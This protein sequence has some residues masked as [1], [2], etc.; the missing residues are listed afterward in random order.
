[1]SEAG[2]RARHR[3]GLGH[4]AN[5]GDRVVAVLPL[6]ITQIDLAPGARR[7]GVD[8]LAA[9]DETDI[10]RGAARK[11]GEPV[12]LRDL[13]RQLLDR[14]DAVLE[15]RARMGGFPRDL[16]S[17]KDAALSPARDLA[18]DPARFR[19]EDGARAA[20]LGLDHGTRARGGDFL[21]AGDES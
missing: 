6:H 19:V 18:P 14:R 3:A 2:G 15:I 13:S 4:L 1:D 7:D 20:R 11:I 17:G 9:A 8:R 21:I 10:D 12:K 5:G 16:A